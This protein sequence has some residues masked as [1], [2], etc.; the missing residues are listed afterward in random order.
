MLCFNQGCNLNILHLNSC[1]EI[2]TKTKH[3]KYK[4]SINLLDFSFVLLHSDDLR[5][6]LS[7]W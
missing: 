1:N 4:H 3:S 5:F 6:T 7:L 2:A